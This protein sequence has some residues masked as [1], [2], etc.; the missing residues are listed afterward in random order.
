MNKMKKV[1]WLFLLLSCFQ[2][3]SAQT[4]C[5]TI[6]TFV[7]TFHNCLKVLNL[8]AY[9]QPPDSSNFTVYWG[10]G[11]SSNFVTSHSSPTVSMQHAYAQ[12]GTYFPFILMTYP[13]LDTFPIQ[14]YL[15]GMGMPVNYVVMRDSC[16]EVS[17]R[18]Y[19]DADNSCTYSG[20]DNPL[21]YH[22]VR[23]YQNGVLVDVDY[24]DQSGNY[25]LFV[26]AGN[27]DLEISFNNNVLGSACGT[28]ANPTNLSGSQYNFIFN[29]QSSNDLEAMVSNFGY[30]PVFARPIYYEIKNHGCQGVPNVIGK[31]VLD[32]RLNYTGVFWNN[33]NVAP[34]QVNDTL[35]FVISNAIPYPGSFHGYVYV[36]GDSTLTLNDTL[37]VS[38]HASPAVGETYLVNNVDS[39]CSPVNNSYDPNVKEVAINGIPA[40]GFVDPNETM[41]YTV[42]FQNNGN[43]PALNVRVLDTLDLNLD[44]TTFRLISASHPVQAFQDKNRLTF[45]FQNI[46]LPDSSSD[47]NGSKG[48][49]QFE[50]KQKV[51]LSPGTLIPNKASIYF[52][53]NAPIVTNTVVS[54]IR[55]TTAKAELSSRR[56]MV[57]PNPAQNEVSI[58]TDSKEYEIRLLNTQGQVLLQ[59]ANRSTISLEG[60]P[61]GLY[62]LQIRTASSPIETHKLLKE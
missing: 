35:F 31:L 45:L 19:V 20:A 27:Y 18:A 7:D 16:F 36:I 41:T 57:Y 22:M 56:F 30:S 54:R 39:D 38:F 25:H 29:C 53:Y 62:F 32:S 58:L 48:F 37:C 11:T 12:G 55:S 17:G 1:R 49:V 50:V 28:S 43:A 52:D 3:A 9:V 34:T 4:N 47:P 42:H 51:N 8:Y 6:T 33:F 46:M 61:A 44:Y 23:A 13:C 60:L 21:A 2:W 26:G 10:D 24:T 59:T 15:P 5:P 40:E 14:N